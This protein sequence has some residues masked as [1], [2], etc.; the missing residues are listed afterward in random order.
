M[1]SRVVYENG[2]PFI[3]IDEVK[4][5]PA[6]FRSF[7]P[8]PD[9]ISLMKRCGMKLNQL[10]VSGLP[11]SNGN[12]YSLF[13]GVWKGDGVYDFSAFDR[14]MHMFQHFSAQD[15]YFNVMIHLDTPHWWK[16]THPDSEPD[17]YHHITESA[18]D[19]EYRRSAADYLK[20]IISY[21]E[22]KYGDRIFGYSIASGFSNEWFDQSMYEKDY[23]RSNTRLTA[24]WLELIGKPDAQ[25]PTIDQLESR[26]S[27]FLDPSSDEYKYL[28]LACDGTG[29]LICF[30]ASEAQKVL[31]HRKLF[32]LFF[33]YCNMVLQVYWNTN[34]YEQV[35]RCPDID[36]LYSPA[37]YGVN[38]FID[39]VSSYQ[40]SVDSIALN[41]KL[42][43]H[44]DDH[45]T[46]YA[47]FPLENGVMADDSY[48]NFFD[49]REVFRR[50][51]GNTM[52]KR[53]AFWWFDFFGGYYNTPEYESEL[54]FEFKV[55]NELNA[56]KRENVSEIA[57]FVDPKSFMTLKERSGI[58]RDLTKF[59]IDALHRCGAPF[60]YFDLSDIKKLDPD[61]YKLW[62]F[63]NAI[64]MPS[65]IREYIETKLKGKRKVWLYAPDVCDPADGR[66]K[67]DRISAVTNMDVTEY[68]SDEENPRAEYLGEK[69][70]FE[71]PV[72]PMFRVN[73][74]DRVKPVAL[75][76][77]GSAAAAIRGD[78]IYSAVGRLPWKLWR[79]IAK[80]AGVHIYDE[81]G[82]GLSVTSQFISHYTTLTEDRVLHVKEDG[83]YK[84][85]WNG[86]EY[87]AKD[88]VLSY[89]AEKGKTMLFVKKD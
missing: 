36:M 17:S 88:G 21:A 55:F 5:P 43:L 28:D 10:L 31:N 22:E 61:K 77:D 38:R 19:E 86:G 65:E 60:D 4:Y 6:A 69:F 12:A 89:H 15:A 62:I 13:G 81:D 79:D 84:D 72:I 63:T 39:G 83:I 33:G 53:A 59:N 8:K 71:N 34:G 87:E 78:D 18:V 67:Y 29:K 85:I 1:T 68:R 50:E 30:F 51:M 14:Q 27:V 80:D 3:E 66:V 35:R 64:I 74:S 7:R 76:S 58:C 9:N 45:R 32:G 42:Y 75:Y 16:D 56:G 11:C 44:E 52:E 41:G 73:I 57:V 54:A 37:A 70:G 46:E 20:A 2:C 49:W 26:E 25:P 40:Y 24:K 47:E 23:D 82:G 48:T